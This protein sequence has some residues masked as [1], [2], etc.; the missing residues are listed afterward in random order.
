MTAYK[1]KALISIKI[2]FI[3]VLS[4]C[5]FVI[6]GCISGSGQQGAGIAVPEGLPD[7]PSIL[8]Q[9]AQLRSN[10]GSLFSDQSRFF[11]EDN[12]ACMVGDTVVV[13]IIENSSSSMKVSTASSR[14]SGIDIGVSSFFG[15]MPKF[16]ERYGIND[17]SKL[18][19]T[20]YDSKLAGEGESDRA[21]QV[22][23]SIAARISEI[24]PN[25]NLSL[26][27]KRV[28]KANN[29]IQFITISGVVRPQDISSDNR[30][31]SIS[32]ADAKIEYYGEGALSDKQ[33]PG[34]GVRLFDNLWPF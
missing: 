18:I 4:L 14:K 6:S 34:W 15:K 1:N 5:L 8:P 26:Y 20:T 3:S 28:I 27:G 30:V 13:D 10:E 21:G 23:A 31:K 25:G 17:T 29:E 19:G 16:A 2:L 9:F 24:L 11:F 22:T 32:L 12:K 33:R 7:T